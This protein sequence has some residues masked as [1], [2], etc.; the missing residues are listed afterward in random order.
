MKNI[1]LLFLFIPLF[2]FSQQ[3]MKV[4]KGKKRFYIYSNDSA[5][6]GFKIHRHHERPQPFG[7][8]EMLGYGNEFS[9]SNDYLN[10]WRSTYNGFINN[11]G[12]NY[13]PSH[14]FSV[15]LQYQ[16]FGSLPRGDCYGIV[17]DFHFNVFYFGFSFSQLKINDYHQRGY[18]INYSPN[19][20]AN[21]H[22]GF[23][24][25]LTP[26]FYLKEQLNIEGVRTTQNIHVTYF[27]NRAK[28]IDFNLYSIL[29]G[30]EYRFK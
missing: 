23:I 25:K 13:N 27:P 22:I 2:S 9:H 29:A 16:F 11:L 17:T 6:G 30:V 20:Q 3:D 4:Y 21:A 12:V 5:Y 18:D 1:L 10:Q 19:Y 14:W 8:S 24:E 15:G 7:V 28:Q 26:H